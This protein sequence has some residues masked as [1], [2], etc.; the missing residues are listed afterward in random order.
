MSYDFACGESYDMIALVINLPKAI[1]TL[2]AEAD[3]LPLFAVEE[4]MKKV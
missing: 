1:I 2:S 3:A 4:F